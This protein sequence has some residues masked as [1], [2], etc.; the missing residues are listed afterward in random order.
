MTEF[1]PP[2][3]DIRFVLEH[4]VDAEGLVKLPGFGHADL[5]TMVGLLEEYGRFCAAELA[6]LNRVGDQVGSKLDVE[7][8]AVTTAPGWRDAYA[9]YYEAGWNAVPFDEVHGGGGFPWVLA[10]ALQEVLNAANMAFALCPML[11]QGAIDMLEHHG[12]EAQ[13]EVYLRRMVSGEWTG[14]MNLTEPQ[15][16]SDVGALTTRA[17]PAG[18][19][20]WRITGQKIFITYGDQDLTDNIVHLVLARVPDAPRGT[21]GISCFI[22]PVHWPAT[23]FVT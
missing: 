7:T 2:I 13:Q 6:P 9:R 18:D 1:R 20:T 5:E 10:V 15:A 11:T 17:V 4:L 14:T 3:R 21:R 16:G 8:G 19:G 12:S 23:I 22:V